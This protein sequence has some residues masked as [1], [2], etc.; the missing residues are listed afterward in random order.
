MVLLCMVN[1][2]VA[3]STYSFARYI[4]SFC[5]VCSW[6]TCWRVKGWNKKSFCGSRP[7]A[8]PLGSGSSK[9]GP[10]GR[11]R[12]GGQT[13]QIAAKPR[14]CR[15]ISGFTAFGAFMPRSVHVIQRDHAGSICTSR[16][17]NIFYLQS[18]FYTCCARV[19][20]IGFRS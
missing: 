1:S 17:T 2:I 19:L 4:C 10:S 9:Y 5:V 8:Y 6:V 20:Q 13:H 14:R 16:N 18:L 3:Y 11:D 12:F 7:K 15:G